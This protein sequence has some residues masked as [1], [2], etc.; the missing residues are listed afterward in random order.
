M[1]TVDTDSN[2]E[3]VFIP[4]EEVL[5]NLTLAEFFDIIEFN[6]E[7]ILNSLDLCKKTNKV[8]TYPTPVKSGDILFVI[9]D[10]A[11]PTP[12]KLCNEGLK[13][14]AQLVFLPSKTKVK[15]FLDNIID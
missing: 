7:D 13:K 11:H 8:Y 15:N 9:G 6:D 5:E 2:I 12:S 1:K 14:G 4:G 10:Y 3:Q